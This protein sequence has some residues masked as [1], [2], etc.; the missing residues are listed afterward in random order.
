MK[1]SM[2]KT[3]A[4][5]L[6]TV[7]VY[8]FA[9]CDG[10][11]YSPDCE[12]GNCVIL[13]FKVSVIVKPSGTGMNDIPVEVDFFTF[14]TYPA[15]NKRIGSGKTNKNGEFNMK[16]TIDKNSFDEYFLRVSVPGQEGY[17][18]NPYNGGGSEYISKSFHNF[19]ED[20]F[21]NINFEFYK[22]TILTI[23]LNRTQTDDFES[24]FVAPFVENIFYPWTYSSN[25]SKN[26][27]SHILQF[28]TAAD[29]YT[30]VRWGKL[31]NTGEQ[32]IHI[33][34]LI[35]RTSTNNVFN[36]NF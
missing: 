12:T 30:K 13:D 32:V 10:G 25:D 17:I 33:D 31:L 14:R 11:I 15:H 23:N 2:Y 6:R 22:E 16:V 7:V 20:A 8:L 28:Q 3:I 18:S 34:S 1:T 21:Q 36:I 4:L 5:T 26:A 35:C 29:L 27:T 19:D 9:S 24:F